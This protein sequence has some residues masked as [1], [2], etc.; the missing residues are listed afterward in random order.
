MAAAR[1][2][3]VFG[4]STRRRNFPLFPK[5]TPRR[6]GDNFIPAVLLSN[7]RQM[8]EYLNKLEVEYLTYSC[9]STIARVFVGIYIIY[10]IRVRC[11]NQRLS[12]GTLCSISL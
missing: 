1:L 2:V 3:R 8:Q 7:I 12:R 10:I 9:N 6:V 11:E 4:A 5:W